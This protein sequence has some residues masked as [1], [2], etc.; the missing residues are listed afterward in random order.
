MTSGW[1]FQVSISPVALTVE[2]GTVS[3][4]MAFKGDSDAKLGLEIS[5]A[6]EVV[7]LVS[8]GISTDIAPGGIERPSFEG[9]ASVG[10]DLVSFLK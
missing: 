7:G 6:V 8:F 1:D 4:A 2:E 10:F 3:W 5:S 9:E